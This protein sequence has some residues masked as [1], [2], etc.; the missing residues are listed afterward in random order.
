MAVTAAAFGAWAAANAGTIAAVSAAASVAAAGYQS[1]AQRQSANAQE[2]YQNQMNEAKAASAVSQYGQLDTAERQGIQDAADQ[3]LDQSEQALQAKGR[4]NVFA[5]A[6]GMGGGSINSLLGDIE[7]TK[8]ANINK[9]LDDRQAGLY[10]IS[11]QAYGIQQQAVGSQDLQGISKPSW[12]E[13]GVSM[14]SAA[15]NGLQGYNQVTKVSNQLKPANASGSSI[16]G[17]Q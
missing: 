14:G 5:A 12:L 4:V 15:L 3:T 6:S 13:T 2:D 8:G 11:Q 7:A 17:G 1:Y 16:K 10:N 9:I